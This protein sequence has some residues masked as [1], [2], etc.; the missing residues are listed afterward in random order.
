MDRQ[1]NEYKLQVTE[2]E[3]EMKEREVEYN[4]KL[5]AQVKQF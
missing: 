4:D 5:S 1:I 2:K 3:K